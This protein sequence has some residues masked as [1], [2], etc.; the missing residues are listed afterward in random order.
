M[1]L[2]PRLDLRQVQ[3]LVMTPQLQQA[4]KLLQMSSLEL[5]QYV[6]QEVEQNPLLDRENADGPSDQEASSDNSEAEDGSTNDAAG[7]L[8][9]GPDTPDSVDL[10]ESDNLTLDHDVGLDADYENV[11][12]GDTPSDTPQT[13]EADTLH[14]QVQGA[15][16]FDLDDP[17]LENAPAGQILLR[18]HLIGQINVDL[19]DP[20][21]KLIA[22][23]LVDL[24]DEAGYLHAD[25]ED[26]ALVDAAQRRT[27]SIQVPGGDVSVEVP[28]SVLVRGRSVRHRSRATGPA[29][30]QRQHARAQPV[31]PALSER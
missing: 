14:W 12:S 9:E 28:D 8:D 3:S 19:H 16:G 22:V 11:W 27:G 10:V 13:T 7:T 20:V 24:L 30:R 25:L 6:E 17:D 29:E 18:D 26:V 5:N 1:A 21:D 31:A 23:Y 15:G 4:I 2:V